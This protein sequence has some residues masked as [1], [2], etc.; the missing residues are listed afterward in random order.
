MALLL[1]A[2]V[3]GAV[4]APRS[5][6]PPPTIAEYLA[7]NR[8]YAKYAVRPFLLAMLRHRVAER[9]IELAAPL[10]NPRSARSEITG[11]LRLAAAF[12]SSRLWDCALKYARTWQFFVSPWRMDEGDIAAVGEDAYAVL[13]ALEALRN[14]AGESAWA[15]LRVVYSSAGRAGVLQASSHAREDTVFWIDEVGGASMAELT[16]DRGCV[17]TVPDVQ[18]RDAFHAHRGA[19]AHPSFGSRED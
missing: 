10:A 6:R 19:R 4:G 3:H 16:A 15:D 12:R 7:L 14:V 11:F 2:L 17:G 9:G 1:L 8:L 5:Q 13:L 18:T